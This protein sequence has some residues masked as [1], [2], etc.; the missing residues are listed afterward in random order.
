MALGRYLMD[1]EFGHCAASVLAE[2]WRERNEPGEDEPRLWRSS[3]DFSRVR[4]RRKARKASPDSTSDEADAIFEAIEQLTGADA[5]DAE[6]RRAVALAGVAT[7]LPHGA[8]DGTIAKVIG[9][10]ERQK[11]RMLLKNLVLAGAVID[12][13]LVRQGICEALEAAQT[14]FWDP[15]ER[16]EVLVWLY[17]LPFTTDVSKTVDIVQALPEQHR[18]PRALEGLLEALGDAPGDDA[19]EVLFALGE[20]D[21]RLYAQ[22][23]WL[24]AAIRRETVSSA[25]RL[26]EL[27]A[28]GAF[29]HKG[30]LTE[31]DVYM[32]LASLIGEHDQ[33]RAKV[34]GLLEG[35]PDFPGRKLLAQTVAENPDATGLMIL[36]DIG[37]P[38]EAPSGL[39]ARDRARPEQ[40]RVHRRPSKYVQCTS[41]TCWRVEKA[42]PRAN[43][44]RRS[45]RPLCPLPEPGRQAPRPVRHT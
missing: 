22:R 44:G 21:P 34:Y 16:H 41:G 32:G 11:K 18:T 25:T 3:P 24:E 1:E 10:S 23:D 2:H 27:A 8:R 14:Q 36:I 31:R 9:L 33:L 12:F 39:L 13:E 40:A 29:N 43:D 42:T 17:L 38:A 37:N 20:G 28:Q 4:E 45:R 6:V 15:S 5:T 26:I 35:E 7:T 30:S 19:E